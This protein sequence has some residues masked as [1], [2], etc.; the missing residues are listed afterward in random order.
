MTW[1]RHECSKALAGSSRAALETVRLTLLP[2]GY[3]IESD[4]RADEIVARGPWMT[5]TKQ[6]ALLGADE[7][8]VRAVAGQLR[9][10]AR[11]GGVRFMTLFVLLFP[12]ALGA[13]MELFFRAS[14]ATRDGAFTPLLAVAPWL[15]LGPLVAVWMRSRAVGAVETLASNAADSLDARAG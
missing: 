9:V 6:P 10:T 7:I 2:L 15:V 3:R 1:F 4:P 5:S 11:L 12:L 14:P 8:R 13:G